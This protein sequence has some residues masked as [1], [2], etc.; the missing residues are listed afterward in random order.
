MPKIPQNSP[1][2]LRHVDPHLIHQCLGPPHSPY[3]TTARL[4]YALPHNYATKAPLVTM[5]RPTFTP[6]LPLAFQRS[7][8]P[9]N[10]PISQPTPTHH[11]E[12]HPDPISHFATIHFADRPT[13]RQTDRQTSH[14]A[15]CIRLK[16]GEILHI[17]PS[18]IESMGDRGSKKAFMGPR[19]IYLSTKF[20]CDRSIVVGCR[21]WND[22]QTDKQNG[23]T[24]RLTLC[25]RDATDRQMV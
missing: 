17:F 12:Q 4:L 13:D 18:G 23:M 15:R 22:R 16:I 24:I 19:T 11:P 9:S 3:Q 14:M 25:E 2:P 8:P 21:S 5:G 6:K 7:P 10:T 1:F 20:G